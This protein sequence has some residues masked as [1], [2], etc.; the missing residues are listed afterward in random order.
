MAFTCT[1]C[2]FCRQFEAIRDRLVP[3]AGQK[4]LR[5]IVLMLIAVAATLIIAPL[6]YRFIESP[7]LRLKKVV[8]AGQ[9]H[10]SSFV[11]DARFYG[12]T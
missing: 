2:F 8:F 6:S 4:E 11:G 5:A 7:I 9:K 10:G 3:D 1:T 12:W